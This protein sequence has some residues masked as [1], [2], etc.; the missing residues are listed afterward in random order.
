L[1][2]AKKKRTKSHLKIF[3]SFKKTGAKERKSFSRRHK[4]VNKI[5]AKDEREKVMRN[6]LKRV[7]RFKLSAQ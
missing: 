4:P 7:E 1:I 2:R 5:D 3:F 6:T